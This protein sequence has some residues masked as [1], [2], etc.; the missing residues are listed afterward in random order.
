MVVATGWGN[1]WVGGGM[2]CWIGVAV[3]SRGGAM[4]TVSAWHEGRWALC[5]VL[6]QCDSG[7]VGVE[8]AATGWRGRSAGSCVT[9]QVS[10]GRG[11][12]CLLKGHG[13]LMTVGG[14][15]RAVLRAWWWVGGWGSCVPRRR[16]VVGR[17][18]LVWMWWVGSGGVLHA[19]LRWHGGLVVGVLCAMGYWCGVHAVGQWWQGL[20]GALW[21]QISDSGEKSYTPIVVVARRPP[22]TGT[23]DTIAGAQ[24]TTR[25]LDS[26]KSPSPLPPHHST[27]PRDDDGD[28]EG[29]NSGD[30]KD[31]GNDSAEVVG[32][33]AARVFFFFTYH[34]AVVACR[35]P[36]QLCKMEDVAEDELGFGPMRHCQPL[37]T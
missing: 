23:G 22:P 25:T 13:G 7:V 5:A 8:V 11:L 18:G 3:S 36:P 21:R 1:V 16:G 34:Y 24:S 37:C 6:G 17:Q 12:A 27:Q 33:T 9:W 26:L 19:V 29:C 4:R 14:V 10:G 2:L 28:V 30:V 20:A 32:M 15:L 31:D 35:P